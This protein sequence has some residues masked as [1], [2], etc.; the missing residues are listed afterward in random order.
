MTDKSVLRTPVL[1]HSRILLNSGKQDSETSIVQN[2]L[3]SGVFSDVDTINENDVEQ[4]C[5]EYT[6]KLIELEKL[7]KDLD[8]QITRVNEQEEKLQNERKILEEEKENYSELIRNNITKTIENKLEE[9]YKEKNKQLLLLLDSITECKAR[10]IND[11][12]D[13]L[14]T[15]VYEGVSKIIGQSMTNEDIVKSVVQEV[16][17]LAQDRMH[18]ILKVSPIDYDIIQA[19][20]DTLNQ[21]LSHRLQIISDELIQYGGCILTTDAGSI[22]GRLE[23]QMKSLLK[24][25]LE[26]RYCN[27]L[28]DS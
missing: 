21:G 3:N 27:N 26:T 17:T 20:K 18:M 14:I 23:Q 15:L 6:E 12:E 7:R 22:D 8:S 1:S 28:K 19:A 16:I 4:K 10:E 24:I 25:L 5:K 11:F 9:K 2:E 13:E